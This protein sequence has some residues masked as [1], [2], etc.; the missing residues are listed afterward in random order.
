M[1]QIAKLTDYALIICGQ[2]AQEPS[3]ISANALAD[4][5]HLTAPT[6]S[7][8]LKILSDA[9]L[10]VSTRGA[11][12]GYQLVKDGT[13]L[14]V[15]EIV[16]AMEGAL[17]M[18]E[19]CEKQYTC[20]VYSSCHMRDSWRKINGMIQ[21]LLSTISINDMITGKITSKYGVGSHEQ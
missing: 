12:G 4:K 13:T 5:L 10:V 21:S 9:G 1:L 18:T 16:I 14:S 6:V 20:G 2:L 17:A 7:K 3:I 19:C 15:A 11:E 8:I